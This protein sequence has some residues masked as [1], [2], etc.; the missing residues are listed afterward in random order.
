MGVP[1]HPATPPRG[2]GGE[3]AARMSG[4]SNSPAAP[5]LPHGLGRPANKSKARFRP[6][7]TQTGA[8]LTFDLNPT[9]FRLRGPV[10]DPG[11][12]CTP[13][14]L[15][16]NHPLSHNHK[17]LGPLQYDSLDIPGSALPKVW[18]HTHAKAW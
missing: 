12:F 13:T 16:T 8:K 17:T 11:G 4:F 9:D 7:L 2:G 14:D 18:K 3:G 6:C 1:S 15:S 10:S 5:S